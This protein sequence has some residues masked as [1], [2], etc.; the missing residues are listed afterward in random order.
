MFASLDPTVLRRLDHIDHA[1]VLVGI[2]CFENESTIAGVIAA[3]EAGL[4]EYAGDRR[5]VICVSDGGST[6]R[7][8]DV[9]SGSVGT[10]D[11]IVFEYVG[12]P[13]KGSAVRAILEAAARLGVGACALFDADLRSITPRWVD[14]LL[15]P[16]VRDGF[17]FVAPVYVRH[18]HDGTITNSLAYPVTTAL[19]GI[20][21]R[22]PIGGEF[23][24]SGRLAEHLVAEDAW[25][26]DVARFGIDIWM[27]T[28]AVAER[29]R[30]CQSILGGKVHDPK[31]PGADLG[32]M[33]R[34]VVGS[35]FSL[36]GRY[37]DRWA[38]VRTV[39]TPPTFG[40]RSDDAPEP[41]AV[42]IDRLEAAFREGYRRH[43]DL[44]RRMLSAE[45]LAA[46]ERAATSAVEIEDGPW[47]TIVYDSLIAY[48][49]GE[50]EPGR[51]LDALIPLYFARTAGFVRSISDASDKEAEARVE[52][53]VDGAV[54]AKPELVRRWA[55]R[56][57]HRIAT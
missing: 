12:V 40:D 8:R 24:L 43:R 10:V 48:H 26:S 2:P 42:S 28:S 11:R 41:V 18:K 21:I 16:V 33:F 14:R 29:F 52:A 45:A 54:A 22:Q 7:T 27:T 37:H 53:A 38:G 56:D 15:G 3:V 47:F 9:A 19:Y 34:Q 25:D 13:G 50:V 35:M 46:A 23:G 57:H 30:I 51:I 5:A 20:R 55:E 17:D 1:D 49:A 44:W 6:D 32:P 39:E 36:A 31:D 4:R